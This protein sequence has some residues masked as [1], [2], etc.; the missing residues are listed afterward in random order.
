MEQ[1]ITVALQENIDTKLVL[2][3]HHAVRDYTL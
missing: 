1:S 3:S 2:L